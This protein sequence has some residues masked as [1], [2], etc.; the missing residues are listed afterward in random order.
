[1]RR[2]ELGWAGSLL[3]REVGR[4]AQIGKESLFHLFSEKQQHFHIF[5]QQKFIFI[6]W[7]KNKSC[8]EF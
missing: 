2:R 5:E 1:V 8:L 6:S 7:S 3:G 4:V